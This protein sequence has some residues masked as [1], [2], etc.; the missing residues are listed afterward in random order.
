LSGTKVDSVHILQKLPVWRVELWYQFFK[1]RHTRETVVKRLCNA[2]NRINIVT[3]EKTITYT[4]WHNYLMMLLFKHSLNLVKCDAWLF[5]KWHCHILIFI[6]TCSQ[7]FLKTLQCTLLIFVCNNNNYYYFYINCNQHERITLLSET[8]YKIIFNIVGVCI[9]HV[10]KTLHKKSIQNQMNTILVGLMTYTVQLHKMH[11]ICFL[12][13][14]VKHAIGMIKLAAMQ[15][16]QVLRSWTQT[17]T[18]C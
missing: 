15:A 5:L 18:H 12:H 16:Q 7:S 9:S 10:I 14:P 17:Q 3:G 11:T 2:V 13:Q 4:M 6:V 8:G 1:V